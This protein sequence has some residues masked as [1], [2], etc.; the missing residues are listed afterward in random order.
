METLKSLVALV[1]VSAWGAGLALR[2]THPWLG[3]A[4]DVLTALLI[5]G[6]ISVLMSEIGVRERASAE[7]DKLLEAT[8]GMFYHDREAGRVALRDLSDADLM[9]MIDAHRGTPEV[10]AKMIHE[11]D[12]RKRAV[13]VAQA[14]L[15]SVKFPPDQRARAAR[16]L[17]DLPMPDPTRG[18]STLQNRIREA[19]RQA[20]EDDQDGEE[21]TV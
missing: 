18:P 13:M 8:G 20:R 17:L 3:V 4:A 19:L 5:L 9:N 15:E 16:L 12:R 1:L 2:P 14:T 10:R 6:L 11:R 7:L 21:V